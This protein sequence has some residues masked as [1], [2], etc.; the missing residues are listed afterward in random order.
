MTDRQCDYIVVGAGAAGCAVA[1]RLAERSQNRVVLIEAGGGNRHPLTVV[2]ATAFLASA[3]P[4]RNWNFET[5]PVPALDGRRMRWNQGGLLGGSSSINGMIYMRG[6]SREYDA[7]R[8][9]GCE[10]WGFEDIIDCYRHSESSSRG[11]NRWHGD[12]GPIATRPSNTQ[13]PICNAFL[14]A[15]RDAGFPVLDDLNADVDE[16]FGR[17]DINVRHGRR[18]S[19]A[20]GYVEPM[21]GRSNFTL[22]TN[23]LASRVRIEGSKAVGLEVVRGGRAEFIRAEREVILC[24]GAINSPQ[25]L[26]LSGV[27]PGSHLDSLRIPVVADLP[28]VGANLRNHPAYSLRYACRE[29]VTAYRYMHPVTAA[30]LLLRYLFTRGGPLGESYVAQGG[31]MR[32]SPGQEIADSIVV[33]APALVTRGASGQRWRD[34]FPD[35]HGFAVSVSLGRPASVGKVRLKSSRP[36]DHPS[37]YPN[38]LD[39]PTDM[40][41]LVRAVQTMRDMMRGR[42]IRDMI[43]CE[44]SPG[45]IPSGDKALEAEIR[46]NLGTYSHPSGTCRMG[47]DPQS[48][49]DPQLR[50]RGIQGLRVADASIMPT[51]LNACTHAPAIMIGEKCAKMISSLSSER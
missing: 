7:W 2:P 24:C 12:G 6:H 36:D 40:P 23:A 41:R 45:A 43:E 34:L 3:S 37:I 5:E 25:L 35:R 51:A 13:L 11:A 4:E 46:T 20:A 27:G 28:Q 30:G 31:A 22:V 19:A 16:G 17:F 18:V 44:L 26:M 21:L 29:P 8:D 50:V 47:S 38:F 1:G 39:D 15:A 32:T 42:A 14:D 33:M 9:A 10:G 48:V 49:V